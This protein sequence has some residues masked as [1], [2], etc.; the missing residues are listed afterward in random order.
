MMG[1]ERPDQSLKPISSGSQFASEFSATQL[2]AVIGLMVLGVGLCM[3]GIKYDAPVKPDAEFA[4][5][6]GITGGATVEAETVVKRGAVVYQNSCRGCHDV[7]PVRLSTVD[8]ILQSMSIDANSSGPPAV[9]IAAAIDFVHG[10]MDGSREKA[11]ATRTTIPL[12]ESDRRAVAGW[13]AG[14][15][16]EREKVSE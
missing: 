2:A 14:E 12:S 1:E 13:L 4:L 6:D 5:R 15:I 10:A 9:R 11:E 8:A 7:A 16:S 3:Y